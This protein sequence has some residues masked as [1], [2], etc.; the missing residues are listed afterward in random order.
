MCAVLR[1]HLPYYRRFGF[2][3]LLLSTFYYA[4]RLIESAFHSATHFNFNTLFSSSFA[5]LPPPTSVAAA[6]FLEMCENISVLRC[7]TLIASLSLSLPP[8]NVSLNLYYAWLHTPHTHPCALSTLFSL[9]LK[10]IS[11]I[12]LDFTHSML[13]VTWFY[14]CSLPFFSVAYSAVFHAETNACFCLLY[15]AQIGSHHNSAKFDSIRP[16]STLVLC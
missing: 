13:C 2:W 8:Y 11:S 5:H 14:V 6:V 3:I 16:I 7:D 9:P 1:K 10:W 12:Y 15:S 4:I